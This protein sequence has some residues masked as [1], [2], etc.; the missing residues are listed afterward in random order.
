MINKI[1]KNVFKGVLNFPPKMSSES[2]IQVMNY[3]LTLDSD[4][5]KTLSNKKQKIA[6]QSITKSIV[7]VDK[8]NNFLEN[9]GFIKKEKNIYLLTDKD[10]VN[11]KINALGYLKKHFENKEKDLILSE[12][13]LVDKEKLK[14]ILIKDVKSDLMK[15]A[16]F[17]KNIDETFKKKLIE[18]SL[19][20][21]KQQKEINEMLE[22]SFC[23]YS[24][25][26]NEKENCLIELKNQ[27]K[28]RTK[29]LS[30]DDEEYY[31]EV[32]E[33]ELNLS[34]N[35]SVF[36]EIFG[37]DVISNNYN[38]EKHR[39]DA[40]LITGDTLIKEKVDIYNHDKAKGML[41]DSLKNEND[42]LLIASDYDNDGTCG[43][44]NAD[45]LIN[46]YAR[47]RN[48]VIFM[49]EKI[50][51]EDA[52]RGV[53]CSQIE[54]EV[55][56]YYGEGVNYNNISPLIVTIDNGINSNEEI[57]KI[58][59]KFPNAK[60]LV[61]DHH[62]PDSNVVM[63]DDR[64]VIYNL[65]YN[66]KLKNKYKISGAHTFGQLALDI[67]EKD[68]LNIGVNKD[69][70]SIIEQII[71]VN[72]LSDLL[73]MVNS[74]HI[75]NMKNTEKIG[76]ISNQMNAIKD[77]GFVFKRKDLT[78]LD[79][80]K[81][82][83]LPSEKAMELSFV[84]NEI[85]E[86]GDKIA[87]LN[88]T[89]KEYEK[90][91]V[92]PKYAEYN[93]LNVLTEDD[94]E[95]KENHNNVYYLR[96]AVVE[97]ITKETK[98][99]FENLFLN[100][101]LLP[102]LS[103]VKRFEQMMIDHIRE[104]K[105]D[106]VAE[107]ET[108][109]VTVQIFDSVPRNIGRKCFPITLKGFYFSID[110]FNV[111]TLNGILSNATQSIVTLNGSLR[112]GKG[113][114][115]DKILKGYNSK[116]SAISYS[117]HKFAAGIKLDVFKDT[118][119]EEDIEDG[120]LVNPDD[121]DL[122][123]SLSIDSSKYNGNIKDVITKEELRL[124]VLQKNINEIKK[125]NKKEVNYVLDHSMLSSYI[126]F[127]DKIG[128]GLSIG[129]YNPYV[130]T[131]GK[132]LRIEGYNTTD[133][134]KNNEE[135]G[136]EID[137]EEEFSEEFNDSKINDIS[138]ELSTFL[139]DGWKRVIVD[140]GRTMI[141]K[142]SDINMIDK[143]L[144]S[145]KEPFLK[146]KYASWG[147]AIV[148]G[149]VDL[150]NEQTISIKKEHDVSVAQ[151]KKHDKFY[152]NKNDYT[153]KIKID[154]FFSNMFFLKEKEKE[155]MI[156][157]IK[158]ILIKTNRTH[159]AVMDTE[160][161]GFGKCP[162]LFNYGVTVFSLNKD[163]TGLDENITSINML[164]NHGLLISPAITN[165]TG[166]DKEMLDNSGISFEEADKILTNFFANKKSIFLAH[167]IP[168]DYN[169]VNGNMMNFSKILR[170]SF[171]IDTAPLAKNYNFAVD[172][173]EEWGKVSFEI[174]KFDGTTDLITL[175]LFNIT[176]I[177]QENVGT[178]YNVQ[179]F[180]RFPELKKQGKIDVDK[181]FVNNYSTNT[182]LSWEIVNGEYVLYYNTP[183]S[184]GKVRISKFSELRYSI[185]KVAKAKR[186]SVQETMK[187]ILVDYIKDSL[188]YKEISREEIDKVL[189]G[190][191]IRFTKDQDF[192]SLFQKCINYDYN[193]AL[194]HNDN[195]N[196]ILNK[197]FGSF[198][199]ND[200]VK[201]EENN[202]E[203]LLLSISEDFY[204]KDKAF[205]D[206]LI[207]NGIKNFKTYEEFYLYQKEKLAT[208]K[209]TTD[210][211]EKNYNKESGEKVFEVSSYL[212]NRYDI[213][214]EELVKI[215]ESA[216]KNKKTQTY[217]E[218]AKKIISLSIEGNYTKYMRDVSYVIKEEF[219]NEMGYY[220]QTQNIKTIARIYNPEFLLEV[221]VKN[222]LK[223]TFLS[224]KY[225][226][227]VIVNGIEALN[228]KY[229]KNPNIKR[230]LKEYGFD[231]FVEL[232][233]EHHNNLDPFL[234][235]H[236]LESVLVLLQLGKKIENNN[237]EQI[238][239][240]LYL[241]SIDT[242]FKFLFNQVKQEAFNSSTM[243]QYL[244][245]DF[246]NK[247]NRRD[248]I[249][250]R[251]KEEIERFKNLADKSQVLLRIDEQEVVFE[252]K[253]AFGFKDL[254]LNEQFNLKEIISLNMKRY[255][256]IEK[257]VSPFLMV[258][259]NVKSEDTVS[260]DVT[261]EKGVEI[262][263]DE[264]NYNEY[265]FLFKEK[266]EIEETLEKYGKYFINF[267]KNA[268][269]RDISTFLRD[270]LKGMSPSFVKDFKKYYNTAY[271]EKRI[272]KL[273][274]EN[275]GTA[276]IKSLEKMQITKSEFEYYMKELTKVLDLYKEIENNRINIT[277]IPNID[278][279]SEIEML[280]E[281]Y[282]IK[283]FSPKYIERESIPES[284][285]FKEFFEY[286]MIGF[287]SIFKIVE[288]Y[289]VDND[290]SNFEKRTSK[291]LDLSVELLFSKIKFMLDGIK[292]NE[293]NKSILNN[294]KRNVI[295][296]G[297]VINKKENKIKNPK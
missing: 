71:R 29:K 245:Q 115:L 253:E 134:L 107:Y 103:L 111:E 255:V 196:I 247:E 189:N 216:T 259:T 160:G 212:L 56:K 278:N 96:T 143:M 276:D 256:E 254:S 208:D 188:G 2:I 181:V 226:I 285:S 269:I 153:Q 283:L 288:K 38:G 47:K 270:A 16:K 214:N 295:L 156:E 131:S 209:K 52:S 109:D 49:T 223:E 7:S 242:K 258:G 120:L 232:F 108:N 166:I 240:A 69:N 289:E 10:M 206:D 267:N 86:L 251:T 205:V 236:A 63:E 125:K 230:L 130:Y 136:F 225:I 114:D 203:E 94:K 27:I 233:H 264:N 281:I 121:E 132:D 279:K 139:K 213:S 250:L 53:N 105:S 228:K 77:W 220:L 244:N 122:D 284:C 257:I 39:L 133:F 99:D 150:K 85:I 182:T 248:M 197:Y 294:S 290:I 118:L 22:T 9:I 176:E 237:E 193:I 75:L 169:I 195:E 34:K 124:D 95:I 14:E 168:Y 37:G 158:K 81:M 262:K 93:V 98:N 64:V 4:S 211:F 87:S 291:G 243:I 190:I 210:K 91:G 180:L 252:F 89:R 163:K 148:D 127:H 229:E 19:S 173:K 73:D 185:N 36:L 234:S 13:G 90:L 219:S 144:S 265:S 149:V 21:T 80:E 201:N 112:V 76:N 35:E 154:T 70:S 292:I 179:E 145:G 286:L 218:N 274:K 3:Y 183:S 287:S 128:T 222:I 57:K 65:E 17:P 167:N 5:S 275:E 146:I 147:F 104:H 59:N 194:P 32:L 266:K 25:L 161:D 246:D 119:L 42:L 238:V 61:T 239:K 97:L 74:E 241:E 174:K 78:Q 227:D 126:S 117:G 54:L 113:Y 217:I 137:N 58:K 277:K 6:L 221:N 165:L 28:R 249:G 51:K 101:E 204:I 172:D 30:A 50:K 110:N 79:F 202:V 141:I 8:M 41:I 83:K 92:I 140:F 164:I 296:E 271:G 142:Q 260:I 170:E 45:L 123:D 273:N 62:Q 55:K 198:A 207:N 191:L 155:L 138:D 200:L 26:N 100:N 72:R 178:I 272:V 199:T 157:T 263:K 60:I 11:K 175:G 129:F 297:E 106:Y 282:G 44:V 293:K 43:I 177:N 67:I 31:L 192:N 280:K 215:I 20:K 135:N 116:D 24:Y 66:T 224:E 187:S 231:N 33:E 46:K 186:Y 15:R 152:N 235:D 18:K 23:Y 68:E 84:Y 48:S 151:Y 159:Y 184:F 162:N 171:L 268:F 40:H 261:K 102:F 82:F 1:E 12:N 88:I